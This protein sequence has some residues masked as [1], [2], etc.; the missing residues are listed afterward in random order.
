[1]VD[2]AR[3]RT[4]ILALLAD[5]QAAGAITAQDIRDF[6]VSS[7]G[8][9]GWGEYT[10]TLYTTG[11]PQALPAG[12]Q[13]VLGNNAGSTRLQELPFDLPLGFYTATGNKILG[14]AGDGFLVTKEY[15]IRRASGVGSYTIRSS[16]N[17]GGGGAAISLYPRTLTLAGAGEQ[18]ITSTTAAFALDTWEANGAV[19]EINP[20]VDAEVYATRFVIHRTHR[21]QGAY[22]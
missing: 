18:Q 1:M 19:F 22:P 7:Y 2:T 12:V 21:G 9:T 13:T 6:V 15:I 3:S 8:G 11:V 16:L 5:G 14:R 4:E 17:I 20:S 10:D